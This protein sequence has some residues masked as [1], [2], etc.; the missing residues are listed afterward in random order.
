MALHMQ[1]P[2]KFGSNAEC[3]MMQIKSKQEFCQI[4]R[5]Q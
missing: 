2:F 3:N 4:W 1:E 5:W